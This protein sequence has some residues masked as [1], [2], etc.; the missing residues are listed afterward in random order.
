M[1]HINVHIVIF[2]IKVQHQIYKSGFTGALKKRPLRNMFGVLPWLPVLD[3][4]GFGV[5]GM[6]G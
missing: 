6:G 5:P 1:I 2:I 4:A 3:P